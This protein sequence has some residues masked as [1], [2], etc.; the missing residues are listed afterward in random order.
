M[1][2]TAKSKQRE[3]FVVLKQSRRLCQ[4]FSEHQL[5]SLAYCAREEHWVF[6]SEIDGAQLVGRVYVIIS[7]QVSATIPPFETKQKMCPNFPSAKRT[8]RFLR[9]IRIG[10]FLRHHGRQI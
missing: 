6:R 7:G 4:L 5:N 10:S 9:L 2:N 3:T 1:V 8:L